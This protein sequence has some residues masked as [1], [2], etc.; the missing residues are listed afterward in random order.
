MPRGAREGW[1]RARG[2][3]DEPFAYNLNIHEDKENDS[4]PE[5]ETRAIEVPRRE[6]VKRG[7]TTARTSRRSWSLVKT[8][9]LRLTVKEYQGTFRNS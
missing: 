1:Q 5:G 3:C 6:R 2:A 4:R 7:P 9:D 8:P